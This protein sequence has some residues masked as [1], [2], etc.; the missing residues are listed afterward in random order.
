MTLQD[1]QQYLM[2]HGTGIVA[3]QLQ[4]TAEVAA[5]AGYKG[6][7]GAYPWSV[8][9]GTTNLATV[10]SQAFTNLPADFESAITIRY[11]TSNRRYVIDIVDE[12]KFDE[13]YPYP[14]GTTGVPSVCKLV[15]E[16]PATKFR[17]VWYPVPDAIYSLPFSYNRQADPANLPNL[18]GWMVHAIVQKSLVLMEQTVEGQLQRQMLASQA[19]SDAITADA[20]VT[21]IGPKWGADPGW[22]DFSNV[23][24]TGT[25]SWLV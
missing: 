19:L 24:Q 18:P 15:Y 17:A 13:D 7:W 3:A 2:G 14:A 21:G 9:R 4:K 25:N 10:A 5:E 16:T 23:T 1:L 22:D 8:R 6:V 12:P 20:P 11:A